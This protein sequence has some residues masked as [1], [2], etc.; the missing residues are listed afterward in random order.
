[1]TDVAESEP[2][3]D[4]ADRFWQ[5]FL[6]RQPIYATVLGDE[7]YDDRCAIRGR[8]AGPRR[9]GAA[10]KG[11]LRDG[12][13]HRPHRPRCRGRDH[14][15]HARGGRADLAPPARAQPPP[16]RGDGP[17]G[18]AAE[19][20][21]RPVALPARGHARARRSA[22]PPPRAVPR[23]SRRHIAPTLLE[24]I[25]AKR[26]AAAPVVARVI[27]QTRRAVAGGVD[28]SPLLLSHPELDDET[29]TRIAHAVEHWVVPALADHLAAL[30]GYAPFARQGEGLWALPDGEE[31]YKTM[32]LASTT[33][34]ETPE[35][36]HE[37][38]LEQLDV[39]R[40][41]RTAI[42]RELG[43]ATWPRCAALASEHANCAAT[44]RRDRRARRA[45][46]RQGGGRRAALVRPP[47]E[48]GVR[49]PR[50]RAVP[51][52][53]GAAGVLL[54]ARP[55][56]LAQRHLL[57]Q[58]L[59]AGEPAAVP[60]GDD[61]LPRG[62]AGPPLP[63]RDR[64]RAD[65]PARLPALRLAPDRRRLRRG[66]GPVQRAAGRRDGPL[67][68]RLGAPGHARRPGLARGATRGRHRHARV[69]VDARA[70]GRAAHDRRPVAAR[71]RDGDRPLHRLAGPGAGVHDR[72]ARDRGAAPR[73]RGARRRPVRSRR[74]STTSCSATARCRWRRCA[75]SCR[76]G[77]GSPPLSLRLRGLRL[78]PVGAATARGARSAGPVGRAAGAPARAAGWGVPGRP[79]RPPP[80][81][82]RGGGPR[83][84]RGAP[85]GG[86]G[87]GGRAGRGDGPAPGSGEG[88]AGERGRA[89]R[90]GGGGGVI[91]SS[92]PSSGARVT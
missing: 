90:G 33:L 34:E 19:P 80:P 53:R 4:L 22:D 64:E 1:M 57:R 89:R 91:G 68:D 14:A 84:G 18:R 60:T 71:G 32:I 77:R 45:P 63:D 67:R 72:H 36:L 69:P 79:R 31:L 48:G 6:A 30:E 37:Y 15:R 27:D 16:L 54:P 52:G 78:T 20:A 86:G 44:G 75:A 11:F 24:G 55:G 28:E 50:G 29:R 51:G 76:P 46:D 9:T 73:A 70:V 43:S 26:T 65:G 49:G 35:A 23:L 13:S 81:P 74:A 83:P 47:A 17:D 92:A 56:R 66:L 8:Q 10:H 88:P 42:A 7:R 25:A 5:W 85:A 61:D 82:G 2:V 21:R 3:T 62:D 12:Q 40:R 87:R 41:E 39:I 58:H 59:P 38:G